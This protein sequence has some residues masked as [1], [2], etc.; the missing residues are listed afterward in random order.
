G[1]RHRS[2]ATYC[3]APA[4]TERLVRPASNG[5]MPFPTANVPHRSPIGS[6]A[7]STGTMSMTPSRNSCHED[8]IIVGQVAMI[9]DEVLNEV[10]VRPP[11][12]NTGRASP[13]A[14]P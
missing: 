4:N 3:A 10:A 6:A 9:G 2:I 11:V 7:T 13:R 12:G 14:L 8:L 1:S 5:V